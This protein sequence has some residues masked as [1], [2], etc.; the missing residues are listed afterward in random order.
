MTQNP[1]TET[2]R[3][4]ERL[5]AAGICVGLAAL[6]WIAFGQA[7]HFGFVNF[8]DDVYVY[9][10]EHV[11]SGAT[12]TGVHWAFTHVHSSN[13]HPITWLS[14][15]LDCQF[16]GL[17]AGGHHFTNI[18]I[19][20][21]TC[22]L[23]FLL[24]R[25]LTGFLWRSAFVA[26]VFAIHPLRVE[27][28]AW[29]A[30]RKDVLSGLFFVLTIA[31]YVWYARRA[32]SLARYLAV[33]LM[34]SLALMSKPMVVTLPF[35]LLL[36][37]YWPLNRF[38][39]SENH[40][41]PWRCILDKI[42]LL[43]LSAAMCAIT[44]L[45]QHEAVSPLPLSLR[46]SNAAVSAVVYLRQLL[47]PSGLVVLYPFPE[48]G[49]PQPEI[50]LACGLLI[51]ISA[52]VFL[53]HHKHPWLLFGWLWY[54]GMLVPVIGILQVGAQAHADRYTYLPQIG[55]CIALTWS[56]AELVARWRPYQVAVSGVSAAVVIMLV[57]C[58]HQQ[59]MYWQNSR[60]LWTRA[61]AFTSDNIVAQNNL[62]NA[63]LDEGKVDEAIP[64]FKEAR[65]IKP[66]D[67]KAAF[68]LGNALIQKGELSEGIANLSQALQLK[69]DYAEAHINLGGAF[70]K[71][72]KVDDAVDHFQKAL[73]LEP[74]Q[75]SAWNDLGYAQLQQ[76]SAEKAA[77]CF[78]K[79]LQLDPT[80]PVTQDNIA[81]TLMQ[82]GKVDEAISY[83][84]KALQLKPGFAEAEY[85]L[86]TAFVRKNN[87][88]DAMVHFQKAL[89]LKPDYANAAYNI[90]I[91]LF[92]QDKADEA[93]PFFLKAIQI[94]PDYAEAH[95]N[96][97][98]ALIRQ[99][100]VEDGIAQF[101]QALKIEPGQLMTRNNLGYVLLQSGK[102]DEAVAEFKQVLQTQPGNANAN[103]NLGNAILRKGNADEA[104]EHLR[105][106]L[107]R[108]P[109]LAEAHYS[110][111]T[112]LLQQGHE[113]EA[114][115]QFQQAIELRPDYSEALNDLAW[116]LA[117][118]PL[119]ST[120]DGNKAVEFAQRA[121]QLAG[122]KD[123]DI[124]DTVAA[125]YAEAHRFA[126]AIR[127]ARQAIA[128]A[129][130][131]GQENR[132]AQLSSEL[133]LYQAGQPFHREG[134]K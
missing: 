91:A 73:Q 124:L 110:L 39:A 54:L 126:E 111:G 53:V 98:N 89:R 27:S 51:A 85:N 18:L 57:V 112:A 128:F 20:A 115:T 13:W 127:T 21:I 14:H 65:R 9:K 87:L 62:G 33:V 15:M 82:Q 29:I 108:E 94:N 123:L 55:L 28:V 56:I 74:A 100:K 103:F 67:A 96:L 45:A 25:R 52:S 38:I 90:G 79:A 44:V 37:D 133:A 71:T 68:N 106:A 114:L 17:N 66:E 31:V 32:W 130:S 23:L 60:T 35:V 80:Q 11:T 19:H 4:R 34:F 101:R 119:P 70:L 2:Q 59:T 5:I 77:E 134:K 116:E 102:V 41:L 40:S 43:A 129:H 8:D 26:A 7:I 120:R 12:G 36:L 109:D 78:R 76:G 49:L 46:L 75:P 81:N 84:Q 117:T 107:Q 64:H 63:L 47:F 104:V 125:A 118:A 10:N 22:V 58:A 48:H 50:F 24:L 113:T 97:G 131:S 72:G 6:V 105:Q 1:E 3:P 69:P 83:Y 16:Y 132:V 121:D 86:G 30:E 88:A 61:L 42:P 99:G 95:Y 122:S 93:V 92:H